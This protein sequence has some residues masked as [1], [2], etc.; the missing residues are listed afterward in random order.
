MTWG[1][2]MKPEYHTQEDFELEDKEK[3]DDSE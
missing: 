3:D 2:N 1:N